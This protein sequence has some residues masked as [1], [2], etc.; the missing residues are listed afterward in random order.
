MQGYPGGLEWRGTRGSMRVL[1]IAALLSFLGSGASAGSLSADAPRDIVVAT[2]NVENLF[3]TEDDPAND[4]DDEFTP[5]SWRRW[6]NSRYTLKLEHLA[7]VIARMKPDII[8]L[9]EIENRRVLQDLS[10]TLQKKE[11]CSLPVILHRDGPDP[12]GIDVAILSRHTPVGTNWVTTATRE[13]LVCDFDINCRRLTVLANHWKSQIGKKAESD[14]IRRA[15]AKAVRAFLDIRLVANSNAAIVVAG[16]FN[17]QVTSPILT[18]AAGFIMDEK[19]VLAEAG[20]GWLFNL[21]GTLAP[22]ARGTYWY[23]AGKRWEAIDSIS[24]TRGMLDKA[25]PAAPWQVR[26]GTYEVFKIPEQVD[27]DGYPI[28]FRFVRSKAKGNAFKT[29]YSDHL[30]VRVILR[31]R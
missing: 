7:A 17:D 12:R 24:V 14:A 23:N 15:D 1:W 25:E 19:R 22:Q 5:S 27:E 13:T 11:S 18:E 20:S 2:W 8:C 6:T 26:A 16:D 3:D 9:S 28:P 21:S 4:G 31:A 29:G 30:P 10:Q